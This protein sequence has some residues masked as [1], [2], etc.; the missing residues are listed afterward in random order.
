MK[1][2]DHLRKQ[3]FFMISVKIFLNRFVEIRVWSWK[4]K[5]GKFSYAKQKNERKVCLEFFLVLIHKKK[6]LSPWASLC[7]KTKQRRSECSIVNAESQ[8]SSWENG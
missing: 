1:K 6:I 2:S 5:N 7:V 8:G 3:T 4:D